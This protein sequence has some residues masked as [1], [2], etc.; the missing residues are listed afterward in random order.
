MQ[1]PMKVSMPQKAVLRANSRRTT[2]KT[3]GEVRENTLFDLPRTEGSHTEA[4][5]ALHPE[6][7]NKMETWD[8]WRYRDS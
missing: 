8:E 3:F 2:D 4:T 6:P 5:G 7:D 1:Q